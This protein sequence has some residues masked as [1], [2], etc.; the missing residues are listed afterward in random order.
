MSRMPAKVS[1]L[2]TTYNQDQYI[3]Q[4][5]ESVLAQQA[6]FAY[7]LVIGE[8]C[9]TDGT[10]AICRAYQQ[11][12]PETIRLLAREK[13]L[14]AAENFLSALAECSGEYLAILDGD[15]FWPNPLKLQEQADCLD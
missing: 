12:H 9:S 5:I 10:R 15:D 14:G 11:Q 13:N 1:V 6:S 3:R 4:G 2:M 7:E 8:D